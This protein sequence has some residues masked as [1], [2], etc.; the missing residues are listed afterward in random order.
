MWW[1]ILCS[2]VTEDDDS[3]GYESRPDWA[4]AVS[5]RQSNADHD[6]DTLS[7]LQEEALYIP[8][9]RLA[10]FTVIGEGVLTAYP[11]LTLSTVCEV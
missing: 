7:D 10:D 6:P 11:P 4:K 2:L 3:D 5:L 1:F 8:R 9:S